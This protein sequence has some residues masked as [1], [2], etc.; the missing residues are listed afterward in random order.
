MGDG[1]GDK[2]KRREKDYR[3]GYSE[4]KIF[5]RVEKSGGEGFN[6]NYWGE[7]GKGRDKGQP[8]RRKKGACYSGGKR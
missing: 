7:K 1:P 2:E 6:N 5:S 4:E 8:G 3:G